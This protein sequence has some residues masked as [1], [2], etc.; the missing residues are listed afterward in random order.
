MKNI[1]IICDGILAKN[2][3]E[4]IVTLKNL[5]HNYTIIYNNDAT[6]N[7]NI[8][9]DN[10]IFEKFDSTSIPRLKGILSRKYDTYMI[11]EDDEFNARNIYQNLREVL[12]EAEI[13]LLNLW[14]DS[15]EYRDDKHL[16]SIDLI[17]IITSRLVGYLPDHPILADDI[18]LGSGEIMEVKIPVGSSF[19]YKRV[20]MFVNSKYK[21]PM[22]YRHN[23]AIV[24]K[25]NTM[26]FPNDT[27]LV[28]GDPGVL[29]DIYT[30]IKTA[31]GQFPSP[32]G[33]NFYLV[34]DMARTKKDEI[35]KMV[36]TSKFLNETLINHKLFVRIINPTTVD[37]L[38]EL[39]NLF[40]SQD[41]E[42]MVEYKEQALVME[43]DIK[44][45]K[46]GMII[47]NNKFFEKYKKILFNLKVPVL[48]LGQKP[49]PQIKKGVVLVNSKSSTVGASVVL[50]LCGQLGL[51]VYLYYYDQEKKD[52]II[53]YYKDLSD[54]FKRELFVTNNKDIN[55]L[56]TLY[57]ESEFLQF[58]PFNEKVL[59]RNIASNL[60]KDI[61]EL[62]FKLE[63]NYQLFIPDF[64]EI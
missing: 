50:D 23:E 60:S 13:Y 16:K 30:T 34:I 19:A 44:H 47:S 42:I 7:Q 59:R 49:L 2:F 3:L 55:P 53:S 9:G 14:G 48:T 6:I 63:S 33:I 4:K 54:L 31:R 22:I 1:L 17:D 64:T 8:I 41:C 25:Y 32:F 45:H 28:V 36:E 15:K 12:P 40:N 27:I 26:I 43:K 46:I 5:R 20:G 39:K 35:E 18:G 62:Y 56:A 57:K 11:I 52:E 38:N 10:L 61:D 21:I 29:K 58:V 51:D 24:T 37:E